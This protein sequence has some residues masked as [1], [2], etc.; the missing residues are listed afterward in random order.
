M[1][2]HGPTGKL[3]AAGKAPEPVWPFLDS[4]LDKA[5]HGRYQ[6]AIADYDRQLSIERSSWALCARGLAYYRTGDHDR[7][8][9]D[10]SEALELNPHCWNAFAGRGLASLAI[11]DKSRAAA[12][13]GS[14]GTGRYVDPELYKELWDGLS[15]L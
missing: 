2:E 5:R 14:A 15:A 8:I 12:D 7:A 10:F 9:R 1:S 4:G 6:E 3:H 11:G 13:F